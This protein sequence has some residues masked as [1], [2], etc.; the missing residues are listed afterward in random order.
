MLYKRYTDLYPKDKDLSKIQGIIILQLIK[1]LHCGTL[2]SKNIL[3]LIKHLKDKNNEFTMHLWWPYKEYL[4][5]SLYETIDCKDKSRNLSNLFKHAANLANHFYTVDDEIFEYQKDVF[6][7]LMQRIIRLALISAD[8]SQVNYGEFIDKLNKIPKN[9]LDLF[10]P[11]TRLLILEL[12]IT[13]AYFKGNK[14]E[15][16]ELYACISKVLPN[17]HILFR[18]YDYWYVDLVFNEIAKNSPL[19]DKH[20]ERLQKELDVFK[21]NYPMLK[22]TDLD[23][24]LINLKEKVAQEKME[25]RK[26]KKYAKIEKN[27]KNK[28]ERIVQN[29]NIVNLSSVSKPQHVAPCLDSNEILS[30]VNASS[31]NSSSSSFVSKDNLLITSSFTTDNQ[32]LFKPAR[33][34]RI[35]DGCQRFFQMTKKLATV[36]QHIYEVENLEKPAPLYQE[37][38][39]RKIF[40]PALQLGEFIKPITCWGVDNV[41]WVVCRMPNE[42]LNH[43]GLADS[44]NMQFNTA[45]ELQPAR[46]SGICCENKV[47]RL[48]LKGSDYRLHCTQ[49]IRAPEERCFLVIFDT[50]WQH[51]KAFDYKADK[52]IFEFKNSYSFLS[53]AL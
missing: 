52:Y 47:Y 53:N 5:K 50:L 25:R 18:Q 8:E 28:E 22:S 7:D 17:K 9:N 23:Q 49:V 16:D 46:S 14:H 44:F 37:S 1:L 40:A 42:V 48:K 19:D 26:E 33:K 15:Y 2:S 51:D 12:K 41:C 34:I 32:D 39:I 21:K 10:E 13:H 36:V 6:N 31:S 3:V 11:E 29:E 43:A 4:S 20:T 27:E 45:T 35:R 38:D 24:R 30:M